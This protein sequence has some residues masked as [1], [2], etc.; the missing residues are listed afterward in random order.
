MD[1]LRSEMSVSIT[2][3]ND[4]LLFPVLLIVFI[5]LLESIVLSSTCQCTNS[6]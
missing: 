4:Q 2:R 3:K 6:I 5:I 1:H